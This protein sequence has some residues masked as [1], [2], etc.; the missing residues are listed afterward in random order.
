MKAADERRKAVRQ[1]RAPSLPG[2]KAIPSGLAYIGNERG[3]TVREVVR[4]K[5]G[6]AL[7]T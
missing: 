1:R 5:G 7:W 2:G 3:G 6:R 4:G